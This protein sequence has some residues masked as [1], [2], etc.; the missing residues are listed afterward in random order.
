[1]MTLPLICRMA[2]GH[3][4]LAHMTSKEIYVCAIVSVLKMPRSLESQ[5]EGVQTAMFYNSLCH[6]RN[7]HWIPFRKLRHFLQ[8]IHLKSSQLSW[9]TIFMHRM[10]WQ[11]CLMPYFTWQLY[12]LVTQSVEKLGFECLIK[13]KR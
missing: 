9:K 10:D 6:R 5:T 7:Q 13:F 2:F 8:P 3:W 12:L 4:C 1:L 11:T